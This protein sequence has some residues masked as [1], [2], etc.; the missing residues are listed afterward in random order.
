MAP[1]LVWLKPRGLNWVLEHF[2]PADVK[3]WGAWVDQALEQRTRLEETTR[4]GQDKTKLRTD[5]FHY[6]FQTRDK[7]TG[8]FGYTKDELWEESQLLII[9][10]ADTTA[11]VLAGMLFYLVRRADVQAR[12]AEE[13]LATFGS[14]EGIAPGAK[15]QS[16]KYL[17]AV[18]SEG[19]R[20]TPPVAAVL[21][22]QVL[23]GG[24]VIQG[25]FFPAGV[26]IG[27]SPY[28][29]G[30][31]KDVFVDPFKFRPERWVVGEK[32]DAGKTVLRETVHEQERALSAFSAGSRGCV[33]K[34][35]AW[36]EMSLVL[37]KLVAKFEIRRDPGNNL[38]G[39][40][41][42]SGR[43]GRR[44]PDQYQTYDI[45]VSSR[46]GPMVQLRKRVHSCP[47]V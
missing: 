4:L 36:M 37:A 31:N 28:A 22:R 44:N 34:N 35:L 13:V 25:Q 23:P 45:F 33:G 29:L 40:D 3:T 12:L 38:G 8:D 19:L 42:R 39:G 41:A 14:A 5:F 20:M 32:G 6:L 11:I 1:L 15:L 27:T 43:C 7:D 9:A 16:C 10:G 17:H 47:S 26:N 18:I 24:A 30:Y 46:N 21:D 2:A